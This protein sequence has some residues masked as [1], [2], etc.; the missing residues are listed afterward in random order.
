[1]IGLAQP[2]RYWTVSG[3]CLILGTV[4]IPL[5]NW[6]GLHY[7]F[8]TFASFC[9]LVLAGFFLHSFWT[10]AVERTAASFLRYLSAMALNLPLTT[11]LIAVG[12][13][14]LG[15]SVA[16]SS[17]LASAT[18]FSWNFFAVRWAVVRPRVGNRENEGCVNSARS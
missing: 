6:W 12:H 9:T 7:V 2:F 13:D 18:L 11:V 17:V 14:L 8:A 16:A 15:L 1:M 10:F 5:L 4:L 3:F